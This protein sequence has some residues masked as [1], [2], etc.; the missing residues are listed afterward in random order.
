M[1]LPLCHLLVIGPPY[2]AA[3][4]SLVFLTGPAGQ[5]GTPDG[6]LSNPVRMQETNLGDMVT[7]AMIWYID[8]SKLGLLVG[9]PLR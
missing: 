6:L 7:E 5:P 2:L 4:T 1:T 9:H 8:V 3:G